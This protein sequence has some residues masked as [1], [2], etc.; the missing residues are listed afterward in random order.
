M[1][2]RQK[3]DLVHSM[4]LRF[5]IRNELSASCFFQPLRS[6]WQRAAF[7]G[8]LAKPHALFARDMHVLRWYAL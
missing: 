3:H 4:G 7:K 1:A 2:M 8:N 5:T 6:W